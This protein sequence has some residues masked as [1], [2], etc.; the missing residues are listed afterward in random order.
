MR[1][2]VAATVA[3]LFIGLTG[4]AGIAGGVAA[5]GTAA[6]RPLLRADTA[7]SPATDTRGSRSSRALRPTLEALR[8]VVPPV[9]DGRLDDDVWRRAPVATD[10]VQRSPDPG[11]PSAQRTEARVAYDDDA[12]YVAIRA[13]DTAPDSIASQLARR[14]AVGIFSDWVDVIIDSF[15]DRRSAYRFSV[16]PHGVKR[17]IYHFD[18]QQDDLGWDAIW[19]VATRIDAQGWTAEFRIPLSQIRFASDSGEQT[20]GLQFG[21]VIA[22][23]GESSYWSPVL[24]ETSGFVSIA[25]SLTGL[26]GLGSPKRLEVMPYAVSKVTRAPAPGTAVP[27]PFWRAMDPA[28]SVGADVKYGLT[29]NLTLTGTINPDFGQVEAD[30]AVVNL[31]AFETFFPERRPFFLEGAD[32]F[33]FEIGDSHTGEGLFYSRRIGRAPQRS[34]I[35]GA[36]HTDMPESTRILGA[37]K[38]T[39]RV[40]DWSVGVFNALTQ[41]EHARVSEGGVIRSAAVEPLANYAVGRLNRNFRGG[42]S[43][44]GV[45][46]TATNRR[47]DDPA[48]AFLRTAA[49]SAGVSGQH[50]FGAD[51]RYSAGMFI[52]ASAIH[53]DTLAIQIAQLAP[54][55]YY[56]RP[57]AD[58][59]EYDPRRTSL[60]GLTGALTL[61]RMG[62][63][64]WYGGVGTRFRTPGFDVNDAGFLQ[65]ADMA[66]A[67]GWFNYNSY[68]PGR[69]FRSW[70]VGLNPSTGL[71]FGGTR[72]WSQVNTWA[73]LDFSNFWNVNISGNHRW[74]GT[75]TTAL[76]GGPAMHQPGSNHLW[77]GVGSD[78]RR[79]VRVNMHF[80]GFRE[81]ETGAQR[82]I[83]GGGVSMRPSPRLDLALQPSINRTEHAW[84][85]VGAPLTQQAGTRQYLLAGLKQT[86]VSLTTRFSYTFSP[87]LSLQFHAQPF[88]SSATFRDFSVV[89]NPRSASFDERFNT[90]TGT[91]IDRD[92][93]TGMYTA[94]LGDDA[95]R[96]RDPDFTQAS[97]R[98]NAVLRWE[99]RPGS[100]LFVVWSHGRSNRFGDGSFDFRRSV[101]DLV[102]LQGTNVLLVKLNYWLNL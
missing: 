76:R 59:V 81:H 42:G 95:V 79:S 94:R 96:F 20:W 44:L 43:T 17:D 2:Q 30:P 13:Y 101:D 52:A 7:D 75:T 93:A 80:S 36:E 51:N 63:G 87:D 97:L 53:G 38:L 68:R 90:F 5:Q 14:D 34:F 89:R 45:M 71:D 4:D 98:S 77:V 8:V 67:Y 47:I 11:Q 48:L 32:L 6:A 39:G 22:R 23:L 84:Q 74:A 72:L 46:A 66:L 83:V 33:R 78:R 27:S 10:F 99:Y 37:A 82:T 50:R 29:S 85:Y 64:R 100:T 70:N 61:S 18:D 15:H 54:Q 65:N 56:Q 62:G 55:R 3:A 25:G 31:T 12:I 1:N 69:V 41:A 73:N 24:P 19:D 58:H 40:G 9:L 26:H 86:T 35:A 49:Y 57:D 102:A 91:E 28:A 21:R 92:A 16:N 60:G 88:F